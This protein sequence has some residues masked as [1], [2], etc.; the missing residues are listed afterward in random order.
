MASIVFDY[1]D[2]LNG[3][4]VNP[5]T[6]A[7]I[8]YLMYRDI[9]NVPASEDKSNGVVTKQLYK[10]RGV[11]TRDVHVLCP[12]HVAYES[13]IGGVEY[14]AEWLL[15]TVGGDGYIIVLHTQRDHATGVC[16]SKI[17][18]ISA[19][20]PKIEFDSKPPMKLKAFVKWWLKECKMEAKPD[21]P[22]ADPINLP[23]D[24]RRYPNA[25]ASE[26]ATNPNYAN[27]QNPPRLVPD[28]DP[29]GDDYGNVP[30]LLAG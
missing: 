27:V 15:V 8:A 19:K 22:Q 16:R 4:G 28:N 13:Y 3:V 6:K 5:R 26:F 23:E 30:T 9:G 29:T 18:E 20:N 1:S 7:E 10:A 24:D 11:F 2:K 12:P 14:Y 17:V 21:Q 25:S